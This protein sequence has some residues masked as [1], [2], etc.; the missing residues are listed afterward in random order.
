MDQKPKAVCT[1]AMI[2]I[3]VG[4]FLILSIAGNTEDIRLTPVNVHQNLI[5]RL[6]YRIFRN[7]D[8]I[9]VFARIC[10]QAV[11]GGIGMDIFCI[12]GCQ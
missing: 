11:Y 4:V 12:N 3:N 8:L 9:F 10:P 2:I 7:T 6:I 1:A 5:D